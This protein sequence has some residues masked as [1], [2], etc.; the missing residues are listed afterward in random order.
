MS[1]PIK[2]NDILSNNT[3]NNENI[4]PYTMDNSESCSINWVSDGKDWKLVLKGECSKMVSQ[5]DA[6]PKRK[7]SYL[8][9]R[10]EV[11]LTKSHIQPIRVNPGFLQVAQQLPR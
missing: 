5:I 3:Y 9:R 6:L 2:P 1:S 7:K 11:D 8:K 10:T 4:I